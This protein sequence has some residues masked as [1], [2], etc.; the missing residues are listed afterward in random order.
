[1]YRKYF[2]HVVC[3][4]TASAL[5]PSV[6]ADPAPSGKPGVTLPPAF[7]FRI[8]DIEPVPG[9]I[10]GEAFIIEF[11][12]L[13]WAG[14]DADCLYIAANS[15]CSGSV[16]LAAAGI[17]PDGRGGSLGGA[18]IGPGIFDS[19]AVHSGRGRGDIP[20][21]L[22]D[23]SV[24]GS[25]SSSAMWATSGVGTSIPARSLLGAC[26]TADAAALVP[27]TT[28][29]MMGLP[30]SSN[31]STGDPAVDGGPGVAPNPIVPDGSGNVL[32]G[33]TLSVENWGIGDILS[34]NW[35]LTDAMGMP[36]GTP[37]G[38]FGPPFLSF[39]NAFGF[40]V[41]NIARI[42]VGGTLPGGVFAGNTGFVQGPF[43]FFDTVFQDPSP[44]EF[45]VEFGAAVTAAFKNP[46]DNIYNVS[47]NTTLASCPWDLNGD[48]FV[49][50]ADLAIL[51][52]AWNPPA[53]GAASMANLLG[54]WG[55]CP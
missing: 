42:P 24:T 31:D 50:S 4:L 35:F 13:N 51:L 29:D 23:W 26:T 1:M 6:S 22:N 5:A 32:D 7:C 48:G 18:D 43:F 37:S 9:D 55:P 39:G 45:A 49:L 14:R 10:T 40:G 21:F 27:G 34:L 3:A 17:D 30:V 33:F 15:G 20:G 25:S 12:V 44:A 28:L 47:P 46:A 8:T 38:F 2:I 41:V 11:E 36:L 52:G 19:P 16:T 53:P 54:S